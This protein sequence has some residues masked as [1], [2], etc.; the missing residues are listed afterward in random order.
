[1]STKEDLKYKISY[2]LK[3]IKKECD[4]LDI[5]IKKAS[6]LGL[7][8]I[9]LRAAS[10]SL[11]SIYNGLEKIIM[12]IFK[13]NGFT[14]PNNHSWH[15]DLLKISVEKSII[16]K[17][18]ENSLRDYLGFRHFVR[19]AYGFMLDFDLMKPLLLNIDDT[20]KNF[21]CEVKAYTD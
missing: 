2:E 10:A 11:Q 17:G 4:V 6:T 5:L 12:K 18:L 16:S 19:H 21:N 15:S 1:M 13:Y 14:L 7:D 3:Q 20:I 9:E 8:E